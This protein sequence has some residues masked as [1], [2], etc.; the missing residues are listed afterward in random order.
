MDKWKLGDNVGKLL[1]L[2][3]LSSLDFHRLSA[4]FVVEMSLYN[5]NRIFFIAS[6]M[7]VCTKLIIFIKFMTK[8]LRSV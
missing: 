3:K 5:V 2:M 6:E 7:Q 8:Y 1:P 4:K